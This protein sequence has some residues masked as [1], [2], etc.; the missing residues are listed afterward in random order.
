MSIGLGE[1]CLINIFIMLRF[2]LVR[3][4]KWKPQTKPNHAVEKENDPITSE[5]NAVLGNFG[6]SW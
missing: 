3:L 6:L 4:I 5:P 2:G 1:T